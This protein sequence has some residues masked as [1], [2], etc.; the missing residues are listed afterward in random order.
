MKKVVTTETATMTGYIYGC[1]T[2]SAMPSEAR[3]KANSPICVSEKPLWMAVLSGRPE[4]S[5]PH[6]PNT[7]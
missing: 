4:S 5:T 7:S 1:I 3:M 2:F 6:V